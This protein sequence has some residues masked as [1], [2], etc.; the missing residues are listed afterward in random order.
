MDDT[1][2]KIALAGL[3]HDIGKFAQEG[4]FADPEF[5]NSNRQLYQPFYQDHFTHEHTVYTAA[6]IDHI[7][8]LLP[9]EFNKGNWGMEDPFI[10]L[11]AGHHKPQTNLQWIIATADRLSSGWDRATFDEYNQ[12][13]AWKNYRQTRLL[14]L[15]ESLLRD[16]EEMAVARQYHYPLKA[17]I[18][19]HL[20]QPGSC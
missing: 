1:V 13:I 12:A 14:P 10:N 7:E 11:A 15:F 18:R 9:R 6:F 20:S 8:K 16:D 3:L 5:I 2:L 17:L 4:M 19:K